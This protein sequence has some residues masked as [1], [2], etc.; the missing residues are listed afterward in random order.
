VGTTFRSAILKLTAC[1]TCA[2]LRTTHIQHTQRGP[3]AP[4]CV[5]E[6]RPLGPGYP[7]AIAV[8]AACKVLL[9]IANG[10]PNTVMELTVVPELAIGVKG[11]TT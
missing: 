4:L 11:F 8:R 6:V 7:W 1:S 9:A 3:K 2:V 5:L 10:P